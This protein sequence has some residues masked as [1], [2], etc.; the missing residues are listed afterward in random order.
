M[1]TDIQKPKGPLKRSSPYGG[2]AN[3]RLTPVIGIVKDNADSTRSGRI[4]VYLRDN[5]G[6][7]PEDRDN[8]RPV[9]FLS[10]FYG[11]TRATAPN[12]GSGTYKGNS[13]SY[14]MWFSPPDI[15]TEVL[16]LFVDGDLNTGF[17]IG[18]I[19][20]PDAL[21][22]IPAI[23]ASTKIVPNSSEANKFGNAKRLP[24]TN[25]NTNN[26]GITN[27]AKY[28]TEA[29]PV[30]SYVAGTMWQQGII[31]D[32]IRGPISSS[33]QRENISRVG[34]GI[35]TPGRPIYDGGY[36]DNAIASNLNENNKQQLKVIARRGG[37]SIVM[38]DGDIVGQDNLIRIR[39]SLGHQI[40]MS[41]DGQTL[42]ILH[43]NGQSYVELGK[44]GTV[45]VYSTNSVNIRTQ[46]DLNLHADNNINIHATKNLNIQAENL[47]V[48]VDKDN[49][50]RTGGNYSQQTVGT[51]TTKVGGACSTESGGDISMASGAKAFVNGSR[52]N[53]NSG[54]TGTVPQEVPEI[55]KTNHTDTMFDSEQGF[56]AAPNKLKS[57]TSRAPAHTPWAA[58]GQG[59]N[60]PTS[61]SASSQLPSSPSNAV[62]SVN[63]KASSTGVSN[64]LQSSVNAKAP[65]KS[66]TSGILN[67]G[68]TQGITGAQAQTASTGSA[69]GAP[70]KGKTIINTGGP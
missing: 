7:D 41:D 44:E 64:P 21:H 43:A 26:K 11:L 16:C 37:H 4:Q 42:M 20:E 59:V 55:V 40:M 9:R 35:S 2:G 63:S 53:L 10:P 65:N 58:A 3:P 61:T 22:M 1:P 15:D 50:V 62:Q 69:K 33:A 14:G 45:D 27:T 8:W 28:L 54:K 56:I 38:D 18:C 6:R 34:F 48:G 70:K 51:H 36:D 31:N 60:T 57:I 5:S 47:H 68:A 12:E 49:K 13:S 24:V 39:T 32:P 52:V 66:A 46:G 30:H 25:V 23:G 67:S 17:Y 29:K 19:P